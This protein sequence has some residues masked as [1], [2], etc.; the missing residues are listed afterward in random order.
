[1]CSQ[2]GGCGSTSPMVTWLKQDLAADPSTC[3]LAYYHPLFSSGRH[4]NQAQVRPI[5]DAL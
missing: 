4:G 1:M 2:V 3:T 5:W